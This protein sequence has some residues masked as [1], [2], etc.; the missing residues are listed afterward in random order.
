MK[1]V[2][3]NTINF[4]IIPR[5][6]DIIK[7]IFYSIE[8]QDDSIMKKYVHAARDLSAEQRGK[9]LETFTEVRELHHGMAVQGQTNSNS[10]DPVEHHFV[11]FIN[12]QGKLYELDG[13]K[14]FPVQHG[15][16]SAKSLLEV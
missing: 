2:N 7:I 9:L 1:I 3:L 12:H 5:R 14:S 15:A 13:R 11:A 4:C 16:T 8:L 6:V 10:E